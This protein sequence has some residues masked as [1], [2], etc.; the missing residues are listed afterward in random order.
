MYL[1]ELF[2]SVIHWPVAF[3]PGGGLFPVDPSRP[4]YV[5]LDLKTSLVETWKAVIALPKS[6]VR[7]PSISC[8]VV[9][10][11]PETVQVRTIGVSNFSVEALTNIIAATGV[12]PAVNQIEAHPLLLQDELVAFCKSKNIHITAY[13]PLGNNQIGRPKLTDFPQGN[14]SICM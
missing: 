11:T 5:D 10:L 2:S 13:S 7:K 12:V 6:K 14:P 1:L 3:A 4:G 9:K 8:M